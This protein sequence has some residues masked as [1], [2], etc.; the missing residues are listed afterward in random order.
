MSEDLMKNQNSHPTAFP[1]VNAILKELLGSIQ[2]ILGSHLI[3]MYLDGSLAS[4]DF[5]D[6]SDID[7][8]VVTDENISGDLFLALQ[9]MHDRIAVIDSIWAIQLEGSYISTAGIRRYDPQHAFHPNIERGSGERLKMVNHNEPWAIHRYMLRERGITIVGPP[10]ETLIDPVYPDELH[11]AML[12]LLDSWVTHLLNHPG[13]MSS[14]GYQSYVVLSLCRVLYTLQTG[15]VA[16]KPTAARWVID[17]GDQQWKGLIERAWI[18]R[19]HPDLPADADEIKQTLD[20]IQ[21]VLDFRQND[22]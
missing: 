6:D 19:H 18:G 9:A 21:Y 7:F 1:E 8:I 17:H 11:Q 4:D 13:E 14:R 2:I 20:F 5:D 3:G 15:G 16:S 10:P 22:G 12:V